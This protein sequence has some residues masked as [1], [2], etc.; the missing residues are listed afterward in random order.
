MEGGEGVALEL[1]RRKFVWHEVIHRVISLHLAAISCSARHTTVRAV[2]NHSH[3]AASLA[4]VV[5]GHP[6]VF[7]RQLHVHEVTR[8]HSAERRKHGVMKWCVIELEVYC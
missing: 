7:V 5:S 2:D 4:V 3:L 1:D 8:R 6:R